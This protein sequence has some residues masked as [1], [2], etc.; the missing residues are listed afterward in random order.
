ME[1]ISSKYV[2]ECLPDGEY[3]AYLLNY[4]QCSAFG[5]TVEEAL[6]NLELQEEEFLTKSHRC[7]GW[8]I[9]LDNLPEIHRACII[10]FIMFLV[11]SL[12]LFC[13]GLHLYMAG[14]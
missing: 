12:S 7:M 5:E 4:S 11:S 8:K 3:Y 2:V 10:C 14:H 6:E 9:W 1:V 13:L